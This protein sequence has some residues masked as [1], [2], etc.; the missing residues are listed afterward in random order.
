VVGSSVSSSGDATASA[1]RSQP[2]VG[3]RAP[4]R[5]DVVSVRGCISGG[6]GA[7]VLDEAMAMARGDADGEEP[8]VEV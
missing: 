8:P 5:I 3:T 1:R 6:S 7:V 4:V 2:R